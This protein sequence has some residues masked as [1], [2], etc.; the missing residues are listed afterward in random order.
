MELKVKDSEVPRDSEWEGSSATPLG[1]VEQGRHGVTKAGKSLS[2]GS[3]AVWQERQSWMDMTTPRV[4][5][6]P[7][8]SYPLIFSPP[9]VRPA[10]GS[11]VIA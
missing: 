1:L 7:T 9:V 4:V 11:W 5:R 8:L 2:L 10:Q 6:P 3:V